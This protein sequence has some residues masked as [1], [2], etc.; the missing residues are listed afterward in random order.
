MMDVKG[1]ATR[2]GIIPVN[3]TSGIHAAINWDESNKLT[4]EIAI[5]YKEWFGANYNF[6]DIAKDITLE[7]TIN[8]L[9]QAHHYSGPEDGMPGSGKGGKMTGGSGMHHQRSSDSDAE[10]Q[11]MPGEYKYHLYDKSKL[12][13]KFILAQNIDAK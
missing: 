10:N 1:F 9:K 5:P 11:V 2:N 4:Y 7:V 6:A 3:D 13:Q 12:K 8:A